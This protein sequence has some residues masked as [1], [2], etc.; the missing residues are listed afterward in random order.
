MGRSA[1]LVKV[2][3]GK[4]LYWATSSGG[5][6]VYFGNCKEVAR[7]DAEQAFLN[8][9]QGLLSGAPS[10]DEITV[11]ELCERYLEWAL[12]YLAHQNCQMKK[13]C[14][15]QWCDHKVGSGATRFS[16]LFGAGNYIGDQPAT[17][18]TSQHLED[19]IAA[20]RGDFR[21]VGISAGKLAKVKR[22]V[23]IGSAEGKVDLNSAIKARLLEIRGIGDN[24]ANKIIANRPFKSVD[25]LDELFR[26]KS[27][28]IGSTM[29]AALQTQV[30]AAWRWGVEVG[31]ILPPNCLPFRGV[32]KVKINQPL[33]LESDL[34]TISEVAK[35]I[36]VADSGL[37]PGFVDLL[38]C[39]YAIGPRTGELARI[40]VCDVEFDKQQVTLIK[41]KRST[42]MTTPKA[43]T[44]TLNE[45]TMEILKGLCEGKGQQDAVFT[46]ANGKP[47][48][49]DRLD[50][51]F[52]KVRDAAG[53]RDSLTL[54]SFRHLWVSDQLQADTETVLIADMAGTSIR[55]IERTYGH[56]RTE[57]KREAQQRMDELRAK[58]AS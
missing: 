1:K 38:R 57:H 43:R 7:K 42:T 55:Q 28:P 35:L 15:S 20:R 37:I 47:W 8:H 58:R 45:E 9:R 13:S 16:A 48:T 29:L 36:K 11:G 56:I 30:M 6:R 27:Q 52:K 46:Q 10:F 39:Y 12:E 5:K 34:P 51:A 31:K 22:C 26:D 24:F 44:L 4:Q 25:D 32:R 18:I 40:R 50:K 21:L 17:K 23:S 2:K 54:Y 14:L 19:F 53:V 3:V 49:T 41:H 33:K